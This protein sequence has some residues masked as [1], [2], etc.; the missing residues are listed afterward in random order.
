[1]LRMYWT[2]FTS[3]VWVIHVFKRQHLGMVNAAVI[4][5]Y[6]YYLEAAR[7]CCHLLHLRYA[8]RFPTCQGLA[9]LKG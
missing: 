5:S 9:F 4:R 2:D 3:I 8:V 6:K 7:A 1:M